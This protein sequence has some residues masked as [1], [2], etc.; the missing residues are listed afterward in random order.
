MV[1]VQIHT[2]VT[3]QEIRPFTNKN[4]ERSRALGIRTN[5]FV[6]DENQSVYLFPVADTPVE[7]FKLKRWLQDVIYFLEN[8]PNLPIKANNSKK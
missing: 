7:H 8:K 5:M 3:C 1:F 6:A 4:Y 2:F